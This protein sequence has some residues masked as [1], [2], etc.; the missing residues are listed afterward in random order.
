MRGREAMH[1]ATSGEPTV[2]ATTFVTGTEPSAAMS[3]A[4]M[5]VLASLAALFAGLW[6]TRP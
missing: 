3:Y 6:L 2:F 5:S 4:A 1:A